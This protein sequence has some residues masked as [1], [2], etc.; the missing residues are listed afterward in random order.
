[1]IDVAALAAAAVAA[2]TPLLGKAVEKGVEKAGENL[3]DG[4][5][6]RLKQRLNRPAAQ[7]A[8][9]DLTRQPT[10]PDAQGALRVQLR[11]ALEADPALVLEVQRLLGS[12][13]QA[14]AQ[15]QTAN[16]TN[17]G[18]VNQIQGSKNTISR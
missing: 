5:F 14:A 11:K 6:D 7:E 12:N 3:S 16:A 2:L 15:I 18:T 4:L 10:D 13:W 9:E 1:M 8:L 17:H